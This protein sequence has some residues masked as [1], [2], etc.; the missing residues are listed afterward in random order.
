MTYFAGGDPET[1]AAAVGFSRL[2]AASAPAVV[3]AAAFRPALKL[4]RTLAQ[5]GAG[6][7]LNAP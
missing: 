7:F 6:V 4:K 1:F 2:R 3:G 5:R